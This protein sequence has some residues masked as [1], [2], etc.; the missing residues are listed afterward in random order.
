MKSLEWGKELAEA[1]LDR[2][3]SRMG[4]ACMAVLVLLFLVPRTTAP[5]D[6]AK[7]SSA[8][9]PPSS[10]AACSEE[11]PAEK[12]S[13]LL[14]RKPFPHKRELPAPERTPLDGTYTKV[15]PKKDPHVPC[16][17]C[18]DYAPEGGVWKIQFDKGAFRIIHLSSGWKSIAS[19]T[20]EGD[21]LLLFNDPVCHETTGTYAW[22]AEGGQITFTAIEDEC[23]IRLRAMNLTRQ[24]W[25]SCRA[26]NTEAATTGHWPEPPGCQ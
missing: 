20:L 3:L 1:F 4:L 25:L 19:F 10:T 26:P 6:R 14:Q 18:P 15:D 22:K 12:W 24:P 21:R 9:T 13:S 16:R 2:S 17:R 7:Q 8:Q 5:A 11:S 23:A